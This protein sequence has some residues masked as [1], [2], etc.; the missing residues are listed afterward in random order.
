MIQA[1]FQI[2]SGTR[3]LGIRVVR[4]HPWLYQGHV[5]FFS[6]FSF[7]AAAAT[8]I[9]AHLAD[10]GACIVR[11]LLV[12][13]RAHNIFALECQDSIDLWLSRAF[14]SVVSL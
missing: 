14:G 2:Q 10:A 13:G 11:D 8:M 12:E 4:D 7:C 9:L 1:E 3:M 5:R 6:C